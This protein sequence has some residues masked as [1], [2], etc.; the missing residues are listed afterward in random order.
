MVGSRML[1]LV[2]WSSVQFLKNDG[3][4]I[5]IVGG[6]DGGVVW[7][8]RPLVMKESVTEKPRFWMVVQVDCKV[9]QDAGMSWD[10]EAACESRGKCHLQ[11]RG[12]Y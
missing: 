10:R 5:E 2:A 3:I 11:M 9:P 7:E 4:Q 8:G 12:R 6:D 1:K